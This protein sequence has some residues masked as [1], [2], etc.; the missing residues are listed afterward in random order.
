[1]HKSEYYDSSYDL[2]RTKFV[3]KAALLD[4][5]KKEAIGIFTWIC[6]I[7]TK[8]FPHLEWNDTVVE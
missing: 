4:Q 8:Y 1:M 7:K 5:A 3:A 6:E 2:L